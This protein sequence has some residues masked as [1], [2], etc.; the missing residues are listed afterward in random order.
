VLEIGQSLE[1]MIWR[2]VSKFADFAGA[3]LAVP[4]S[5]AYA[6][7]DGLFQHTLISHLAGSGGGARD[8]EENVQ[9][10]LR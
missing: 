10:A 5:V 8:L 2:I 1:R 3:P 4:S 9:R 6:V 7:L